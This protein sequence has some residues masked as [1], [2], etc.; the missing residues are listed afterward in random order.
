MAKKTFQISGLHCQHCVSKVKNVIQHFEGVDKVLISNENDMVTV[1]AENIPE[2][3]VLNDLL[4]NLGN[5]KLSEN[6]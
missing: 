6:S 3:A 1:E 2:I 5:Y 4:E